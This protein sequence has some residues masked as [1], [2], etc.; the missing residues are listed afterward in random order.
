MSNHLNIRSV[1]CIFGGL[2]FLFF[3]TWGTN[4]TSGY[5]SAFSQVRQ[6][7]DTHAANGAPFNLAYPRLGM[8]WPNTWEQSAADI[9][10]YDW[11]IY[12]DWNKENLP[13]IKTL[14]PTQLMLNSTNACELSFN[15]DPGAEP[16]E[17]EDV[18][19]IPPEWFLTQVGATLTQP[20][21]A[22][23]TIFYVSAITATDGSETYDLFIP[24]DTALIDGESVYINAV[25]E[26]AKTLTVQRGYVRPASSHPVGTRIAAHITF[27]P[28]SWLLNVSTLSPTAV[29]SSTFGAERWSDYNARRAIALMEDPIWDGLLI[30]RSDANESWLIGNSTARSIDPD[31]TNTLLSD[32]SAFDSAWSAG[33]RQ[34]ESK[35]RTAIG[36]DRIIFVNWGMPNYDLLNG[37]NF[38]GFPDE[39]ATA[40]GTAWGTTVFGSWQEKGSYFD[41]LEQAQQPNLT[42]IETYE[43][44]SSPD[45]TGDGSY[46]NPCEHAGFTPN[47]RKMRFGL[48]TALLNDGFFSYEINTN[49]HGSLCLLWFDEYDNTGAGRGYLGQPLGAAQ[50][51]IPSLTTPNMVSAGG[52]ESMSDLDQWDLWAYTDEGYSATLTLDSTTAAIGSASAKIDVTQTGG[53]GWRV[54]YSFEPFSVI[55]GTEYTL[56]FWAKADSERPIAA[57][58]QQTEDPWDI[59]LEYETFSLSDTWQYYEFSTVATGSDPAAGLNFGFGQQTGAVWLDDVRLQQGSRDVWRR[60]FSGGL[61]LVNATMTLQTIPL[62]EYYRKID[63]SQAPLVNDGDII[64]EV[65]LPPHD[66]LIL[67]RFKNRVF[68]PV[69]D[70]IYGP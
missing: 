39:E 50:R 46:D 55:S 25:N 68:L 56:S 12:G 69:I 3:F 11:V 54:S 26:G 4:G 51:A 5:S 27:W 65:T 21:D 70:R 53:V 59:W 60:D 10:R 1:I 7:D 44:D 17:N 19:A 15:A 49:G 47:Y 2:L 62:G 9:A 22:V 48:A 33:L 35:I 32:Y 16:W 45:A 24:G 41:W 64:D 29:V 52:F 58:V 57:W 36:D 30:D 63:G 18:L 38:E 14:N 67:I 43:D 31:Q 40:Y 28:N 37:N 13:A 20:V 8:W 23:T 6:P 34:Y 66:G 61:A 42:T